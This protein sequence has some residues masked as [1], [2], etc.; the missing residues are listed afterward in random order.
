MTSKLIV[1]LMAY[2]GFVNEA[3]CTVGTHS[4]KFGY[5][6][7]LTADKVSSLNDNLV[8]LPCMD[9]RGMHLICPKL[10][11]SKLLSHSNDNCHYH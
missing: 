3:S 6:V 10:R 8:Y 7:I 2:G 5:H 11:S 4:A 1:H 9:S